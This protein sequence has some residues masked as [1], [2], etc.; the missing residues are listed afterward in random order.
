MAPGDTSLGATTV[1]LPCTRSSR[2]KLRPVDCATICT[3]SR[4]LASRKSSDICACDG[5]G[6]AIHRTV[7]NA[8]NPE[9]LIVIIQEYHRVI[10]PA[11]F[12]CL[13]RSALLR[14]PNACTLTVPDL[15]RRFYRNPRAA[16]ECLKGVF[17]G[18]GRD[19]SWPVLSPA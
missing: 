11:R 15:T 5:N 16:Q 8:S 12:I 9:N 19:F 14:G 17:F 18:S 3:K 4:R 1:T 10:S 13:P 2:M 6:H 7:T